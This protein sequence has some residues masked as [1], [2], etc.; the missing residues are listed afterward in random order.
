MQVGRTVLL[1]LVAVIALFMA[2]NAALWLLVP[3]RA[4]KVLEMPLLTGAGLSSQMDIG[5]LFLG[6]ATFTVMALITRERPWFIAGAVLIL[7]AAAYRTNAYLFHG[8]A[9]LAHMVAVEIVI[10]AILITAS[11]VL[12]REAGPNR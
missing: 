8:A 11:R 7:G 4:A 12:V 10:G 6:A 9:F 5:A 1:V 3:E 2:T